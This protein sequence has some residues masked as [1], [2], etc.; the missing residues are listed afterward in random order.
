MRLISNRNAVV[1]SV[2][3]VV[4]VIASVLTFELTRSP[5]APHCTVPRVGVKGVFKFDPEQTQDASIIAA[6]GTHLGLRDHG[7][8]IALAASLGETQLRNLNHG[9]RDSLGLFQQRPSQGWGTPA[10]IM[11]P[12]YAATAFYGHLVKLP[13]WESMPVTEAVQRIQLSATPNAYAVWESRARAL[14]QAF[15]GEIPAGVSCVLRFFEGP[16]PR[17][18][19][20]R[21]IAASQF[22]PRVLGADLPTNLGWR[23]ATWTVAH[24]YRY[25]IESVTFDGRRWSRRSGRWTA[26]SVKRSVVEFTQATSG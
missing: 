15:T 24:A 19:T 18:R 22:G 14:A 20:L 12:T 3:L 4:V 21:D 16:P 25:H 13:G 8:T 26:S 23:V 5:V 1:G 9:D 11:D 2:V 10:Q 17:A 7:V 6:V